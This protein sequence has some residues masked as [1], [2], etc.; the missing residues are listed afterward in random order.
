MS[1][2]V[3]ATIGFILGFFLGVLALSLSAHGAYAPI[4]ANVLV[5]SFIPF[6]G[7]LIAIFGAPFVWSVYFIVIPAIDSQVWRTTLVGLVVILHLIPGLWFAFR[8]PGL[9]DELQRH[10]GLVFAY[11]VALV[12]TMVFLTVFSSMR[13]VQPNS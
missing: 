5:I 10:A 9:V 12:V 13:R 1:I 3:R 6:M 11:V 4:V 8:D 7:F 2:R